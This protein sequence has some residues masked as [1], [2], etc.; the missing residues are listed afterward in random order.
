MHR[1]MKT[2]WWSCKLI[3]LSL[4][5]SFGISERALAQYFPI[6]ATVQ[7]PAPQSPYLADYTTAGRDRLIVTLLNRDQQQ[8]LLFAKLRLQLKSGAFTAKNREE[9][10]YPM[11][12]LNT[13]VPFRLTSIDLAPYL[14]PQNLQSSGNLRNGLLPTG[15]AEI[16]VQVIDY[17]TGRPLS[18]WHTAR[19]YLDVKKPPFLNLPEQD[20]QVALRDPLFIRF[21]WTP[22][23]QGLS[24][25]EYEFV[26]KELPDNGV[27]PQSAF[28]YGQEIYRTH[29]RSTSLSYT[30]LE[31]L[32]FPNR[33]YAWQ[34]RALAREGM[35]EVGMFEHGGYSEISWFTLNDQ[36]DAPRGLKAQPRFAKVDL[37]WSKVIGT[38]GYIV[39]CR[40]KTKLNVYEWAQTEVAGEQLTL[41][42]LKPGWTYEWRVGTR[43]TGNRPVFSEVREF[44]LSKYNE[45]LLAD[46]G[47]EP[48]RSD[49]AKEPHLG[50]R[51]GD[52]VTIGGDYPMTITE[53]TPLG[54]G[55]YAGKGKTRLKTIIDAPIAVRFDRLRI[56]ID[57]YQIDGTVEA[58]YDEGKGKI[59][60]TD[61]IDDGGKDLRP[62]TLRIREQKL[63]FSL[64][65]SPRFFLKRPTNSSESGRFQ[66]ETQDAEGNP[67][68]IQLELPEGADYKSIFPMTV[69][70]NEGNSYQIQP[71][72]SEPQDDETATSQGQIALKAERVAQVGD[73]N[74]DALSKKY[75]QVHFERGQGKYAFDDGKEKWY[76]KSVK[77]D[78][79]YKPFAK[80]YIA[81]WKLIPE[82][83]T[84]VVTAHY[85][86]KKSIDV[87]KLVFTS[88]A[89]S[90]ALPA[91][92]DE[93][94]RT[95]SIKL[96]SVASG[97][98]YDVFAVYE[99]E[100]LGKLHVVSYVKQQHKVTLVPINNVK[101]DKP[102]I[103]REL[104]A[105]YTPVGIH[106]D[107]EVDE[108]MRGDYS[109]EVPS[110]QDKLLSL[111]GKSFWGYDKEVKESTEM[112]RLQQAYQ[113]KA[114]TL[115]GA[116]L[117][118]LDGA[119]GI[120]GQ[121][122][123]LL[124]E[125]PRKS[126]FGYLF[127]KDGEELSKT[128]AHE[129]GHG[130]F[131]LQHTFDS[132]YAG[133][134]FQDTS[135]NLMDYAKG[136]SLA[137]F[138]WNVMAN[139]ALFTAADKA[140][141]GKKVE[142]T[143]EVGRNVTRGLAPDGRVIVS[144]QSK[145]EDY[146]IIP[147]ISKDSNAI[148]GF[149]L[150]KVNETEPIKKFYWN[151]KTY[152]TTAGETIENCPEI[153]LSYYSGSGSI[154]TTIY[155]LVGD[156]CAFR[157]ADVLY[158]TKNNKIIEGKKHW[159]TK[160]L[161]NA[162]SSCY[163]SFIQDIKS[164]TEQV[165]GSEDIIAKELSQLNKAVTSN[166]KLEDLEDLILSSYLS[167]LRSLP[168]T[169]IEKLLQKVTSQET[170]DNQS[171]LVV[172][173]LMNAING[174]DY[175]HFYSLLE[176]NN[177]KLLKF[178]VREMDDA[179]ILF[180]TNDNYTNFIGALVWMFNSDNCKSIIERFPKKTEDYA[181]SVVNLKPIT[182]EA[183]KA[184][185][186][187]ISWS[188]K[189]N[190][191]KYNNET[192]YIELRD[193]YTTYSLK[194]DSYGENY[195]TELPHEESIISLPPLTP[196][197]IVPE[198]D[199]LPLIQTALSGGGLSN[200]MYIVPAIFLK[201][202]FDKIRND[203]IEKGVVT[204]LDVATI[205][206]SGGTALATKVHWIRRAWALAEVVG[207]VGNVAVNTQVVTN[208]QLRKAIG[209][210]NTAMG[211]IGLKN[212]GQAG[213]KFVKNLP[214]Q[215]RRLLQEKTALKGF[216]VSKYQEWKQLARASNLS[217][218]EKQLLRQQEEVWSF[219]RVM[220]EL[221]GLSKLQL[222]LES[223]D[224]KSFLQTLKIKNQT[225]DVESFM[226]TF[227]ALHGEVEKAAAGSIKSL[228]EVAED[229]EYLLTHHLATFRDQGREK[230]MSAFINE[231]MQTKDKF[232][233]GAT[234]LEV[235][236]HP[237]KYI[238]PKYSSNLSNLELEGLISHAAGSGNFRF[239]AKWKIKNQDGKEIDIFVDTKNYSRA[240]NMF[241]D[242]GQF[243]AYLEN[244][245]S[246]DQLY[247]IQQ[248]GRG[249]TREQIINR[250]RKELLKPENLIEVFKIIRSKP[251]LNRELLKNIKNDNEALER[252]SLLIKD[253]KSAIYTSLKITK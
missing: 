185:L 146:Y 36:C 162:S 178:L 120:E 214:E 55:W 75:G 54:D 233:A 117:F 246:F 203:K 191:G 172:L 176:A 5:L 177:N 226:S 34:V 144:W 150:Y 124:G 111:V 127:S 126:R 234:T 7:W 15:Y 188:T 18:D 14:Q 130:L 223:Q 25:T 170:L 239:D 249:V 109:W 232:K 118:V 38:T 186:W 200:Q 190:D 174:R 87:S 252:L 13:G 181:H 194:T 143:K 173:R 148:R 27:A 115:E 179:S 37:S 112:L 108:R 189:H 79:F 22:R 98:A 237:E 217:A 253:S 165:C 180:W 119:K 19:A 40:P 69:T 72:E 219:L 82:G 63:G 167:S 244:I 77:L 46:C 216:L 204:T 215:S 113:A 247:I 142:Y 235:V 105:V 152:A 192:G 198:D 168:Y 114:G 48:V 175:P 56:N 70:D 136:T 23:H 93:T 32:L 195:I 21:Q 49:L 147:T 158:D 229:L 42:Q 218:S 230:Q 220:D 57:K 225:P 240:S 250:L 166:F 8:P 9:V 35:N 222:L 10:A 135:S 59:A 224:I 159:T 92:Y 208:P 76:Q 52:V 110:E 28:A 193:I 60:N 187:K 121:K 137:A 184:T 199:R 89:K 134:K 211:L 171:E 68:T 94:S 62:A 64:P 125:M 251:N 243:K 83:E 209:I 17:Y 71:E 132:E 228:D 231:M 103:E 80:D 201:Y 154:K 182:Y 6:H 206:L 196:I 66:L 2:F 207:A 61:Y 45:N 78:R 73:F 248:G 151:D 24:G 213:Y 12:E 104:N 102:Q 133:K 149:H 242:L 30:H 90:P 183:P 47:K 202:R 95:W 107:V 81:P 84:D 238:S 16:S 153:I 116:Y 163:A 44:T 160:R 100:V 164:K 99:G 74:A 85:E 139:P 26:L 169:S 3:L 31:P 101:L 245:D 128:I 197:I 205:A 1:C 96:P 145:S 156:E 212:A 155:E 51:A 123:S 53:V 106:F 141:E 86:G 140:E 11:L 91:S 236:R 227:K 4:I 43:C 33:R 97:A 88:D 67:Q 50:I 221:P 39:E 138:Q 210:Y 41:A 29:T 241:G 58:S 122:G 157:Y 161:W 131:T 129:L 65:E 20:A